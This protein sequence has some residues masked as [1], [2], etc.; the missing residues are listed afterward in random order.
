MSAVSTL[1][2]VARRTFLVGSTAV[3]GGVAFGYYAY[4]KPLDNPLKDQ[5]ADGEAAI[6]QFIKIDKDGVT[7]IT[8]RAD[9]G[10]G[11]YSIQTYLLAEELDV[12]PMTVRTSVGQPSAAYYNSAVL[13]EG[14]PGLG[15]FLGKLLGAQMTGGS[16]TVPDLFTRLREAAAVARE[17]LIAAAALKVEIPRDQLKTEDGHVVLPD[18][19]KLSYGELAADAAS[20]APVTEVTLRD[21][22]QWKYLG[23]SFPRTDIAAKSTGTQEYGIDLEFD[24]ML[25]ATVLSNPGRGGAAKSYNAS[26]AM[27]MRGIKEVVPVTEGIGVVGDN[28]WRVIQAALAVEV[29]YEHASYPATSAEMWQTLEEHIAPDFQEVQRRDDGDASAQ[30]DGAKSIEVEY[31]LP[32]LAHAPL[33]P[34]NAVVLYAEDGNQIDIWTGTQI[35]R[36]IQNKISAQHGL[37]PEQV[38]VHVLPMGGSFGHRLELAYVRQ[39]VEIAKTVKGQHVKMTFSREQDFATEFPRPMT[40]AKGRGQ[41]KDGKVE[42]FD[43]DLVAPSLMTSWFGRI[44]NP[45]PGPDATITTGADD[46]PYAIPNYRVTGYRSPEMVPVSSWR[47]VGASQNG[48]HHECLLDELIHEAGADALEER[49][50][51]CNDPVAKAVLEEAGKL[52]DWSGSQP[53][54]GVGRGVAM[55]KSFGVPCAEIVEVEQT[56]AGIAINKV[57]CVADVGTVL[58]PSNI[59]AQMFGGVIYGL[60]HAMNCELTFSDYGT[61]QRNFDQYQGMRL[62]QTP[63]IET[64]ALENGDRIRGIGEPGTP[65]AGPALANAIFAATGQRVRE[66]PLYKTVKFV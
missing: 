48:F 2:K 43:L 44:D 41:V 21:S 35:P 38:K 5:L 10:Q 31:R 1:G 53:G 40:I 37:D 45:I 4:K 39:A 65:P 36:F 62:Y 49:L 28:T 20:I 51:L 15:D 26:K 7:L 63:E 34:L 32:H 57:W 14:A 52:A 60:G 46:Q 11:A 6:T 33:E 22:S 17:T 64:K 25:Y 3:A 61:D 12:D 16:S 59:E 42:S 50:R 55:V 24:G 23:K 9:K 30:I 19:S 54:E 66:L 47:S 58:D 13:E 29:E 18:G 56:D 8:P 27:Q